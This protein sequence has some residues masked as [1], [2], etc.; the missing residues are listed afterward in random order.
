MLTIDGLTMAGLGPPRA[1]SS[2]AHGNASPVDFAAVL[3]TAG[4]RFRARGSSGMP[5]TPAALPGGILDLTPLPLGLPSGGAD[6]SSA[7]AIEVAGVS[8]APASEMASLPT[9]TMGESTGPDR[10]SEAPGDEEHATVEGD[11]SLVTGIF[12]HGGLSTPPVPPAPVLVLRDASTEPMPLQGAL[13]PL[14][15]QGVGQA[16]ATTATSPAAPPDGVPGAPEATEGGEPASSGTGTPKGPDGVLAGI[17]P[18][19]RGEIASAARR[20]DRAITT[21]GLERGGQPEDRLGPVIRELPVEERS[22]VARDWNRAGGRFEV[23]DTPDAPAPAAEPTPAAGV[24]AS[25]DA[26]GV[27]TNLDSNAAGGGTPG[28][29]DDAPASA[30]A[31]DLD[32]PRGSEEPEPAAVTAARGVGGEPQRTSGATEAA[33]NTVDPVDGRD[34]A[35]LSARLTDSVRAAASN[36]DASIR[37]VLSPPELGHLDIRVERTDAGLRVDVTAA[38]AEA[39]DLIQQALPALVS[40]LEARSLRVDSAE[41][42]QASLGTDLS[43][44]GQSD[45]RQPGERGADGEPAWSRPDWSEAARLEQPVSGTAERRRA[46]TGL[47]DLVA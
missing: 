12:V 28:T 9:A 20:A 40:G 23:T 3:A 27:A 22:A 39:A 42:R 32:G 34:I 30:N 14:D 45:A 44:G 5:A 7:A 38:T 8:G 15:G 10:T 13:R 43:R 41:V 26:S 24:A 29:R 1:T 21:E 46:V 16:L 18:G 37:L 25:V 47:L 19:E 4:E 11:L 33:A 2:A 35:A 17:E 6:A 31:P 36:G